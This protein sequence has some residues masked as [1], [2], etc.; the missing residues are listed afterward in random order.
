MDLFVAALLIF[1][2]FLNRIGA[3]TCRQRFLSE[4]SDYLSNDAQRGAGANANW[5]QSEGESFRKCRCGAADSLRLTKA[6][7]QFRAGQKALPNTSPP[8]PAPGPRPRPSPCQHFSKTFVH[9]LPDQMPR[10]FQKKK[11]KELNENTA[12]NIYIFFFETF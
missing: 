11:E 1:C 4:R 9:H 8:C 5:N 10:C 7:S 6:D 2:I 3:N 12:K